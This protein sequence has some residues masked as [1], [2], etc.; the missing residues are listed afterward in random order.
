MRIPVKVSNISDGCGEAIGEFS[1]PKFFTP[2]NDGYN[3][4]WTISSEYLAPGSTIRAFDR[5]GR[6]IAVL[7]AKSSWDGTYH[8]LDMPS[9]DYW[10]AATAKNGAEF[11]SHFSLQ[12]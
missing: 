5:F 8:G 11:K 2:N 7:T 3:D 9:S 4:T 10:F 12:R 1:F 6:L